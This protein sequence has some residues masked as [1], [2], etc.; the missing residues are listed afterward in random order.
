MSN[1]SQPNG[2]QAMLRMLDLH[3]VERIFGLC[4]DTSLPLYDAL[5]DSAIVHHLLRDERHAAYAADAYARLTGRV[6]VCEGPS[7]G[8]ATHI[9]PGVVEASESSVPV[10]AITTDI[11]TTSAGR[12][13]LTDLDQ[14]A[15]FRPL[16]RYA[17]TIRSG[18][19]LP[20]TVRAAFRAMTSLRPAAAQLGLPYDIQQASVPEEEVWADGRFGQ[21]PSVRAGFDHDEGVRLL[22]ILLSA[23][24]PL[25]IA[26]G[27]VTLSGAEDEL[28]HFA[29]L[30]DLPVATSVSGQGALAETHP[31]AVGVVGSNGGTP[32]T[33]EVVDRADLVLFLGCRAGSVTT[34]RWRAPRPGTTVLHIDSDPMVLGANYPAESMV[35]SDIR[36]ALLSC[37]ALLSEM[38]GLPAFGGREIAARAWQVKNAAFADAST[39]NVTPMT[40]ARVVAALS[41]SLPDSAILVADPGTPC[42]YLSAY[43]R[44]KKPGRSLIT[45]RAHGALGWSIGASIGAQMACPDAKIVAVTGDGS[46]GFA[47]GELETLKRLALPITIVVISNASF[48]WIKAG[49]KHGYD[50]RYFSVDFSATD[51]ATVARAYGLNARTAENP[52]A[53]ELALRDALAEDGGPTLVDVQVQALEESAAPVSEWVA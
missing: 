19:T 42:P 52:G 4:G 26:G 21:F 24:R 23:D 28:A 46:F 20:R 16:T 34:E 49:Q 36:L 2:A 12:Y 33:R 43:F 15:V 6:G 11:A 8:G 35:C 37:N 40:P 48:G 25:I 51:H 17:R 53:L 50:G 10:L 9:L 38:A 27:G 45:N 18:E 14:E 7:G 13:A 31:C 30:L 41:K 44:L 3:G 47:A 29:E 22:E 1:D 5:R 32:A 39:A